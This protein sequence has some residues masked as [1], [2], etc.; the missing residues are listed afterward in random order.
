MSRL[1]PSGSADV[2]VRSFYIPAMPHPVSLSQQSPLPAVCDALL[3]RGLWGGSHAFSGS[4]IV[5]SLPLPTSLL[6]EM[7]PRCSSMMRLDIASPSPV[8][9]V[10]MEK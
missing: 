9:P 7:V 3:L 2:L 4:A 8:P 5:K 1:W 10:R 6:I